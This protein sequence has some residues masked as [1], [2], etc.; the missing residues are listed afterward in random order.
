M[1][2]RFFRGPE[3]M[4]D[5]FGICYKEL[6]HMIMKAGICHIM[7]SASWRMRKDDDIIQSESEGLKTRGVNGVTPRMKLTA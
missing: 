5:I 3:L 6:V 1:Q 7:P 4:E 2:I